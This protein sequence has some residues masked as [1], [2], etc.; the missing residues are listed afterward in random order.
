M[1]IDV[2][3]PACGAKLKLAEKFIRRGLV[4]PSC[5]H[6]FRLTE[7]AERTSTSTSTSAQAKGDSPPRPAAQPPV[8]PASPPRSVTEQRTPQLSGASSQARGNAV[9]PVGRTAPDSGEDWTETSETEVEAGA[10]P[11]RHEAGLPVKGRKRRIS[12]QGEGWPEWYSYALG[13]VGM[14]LLAVIQGLVMRNNLAGLSPTATPTQPSVVG[15]MGNAEASTT[16]AAT[17]KSLPLDPYLSR[18]SQ[19]ELGLV[20]VVTSVVMT[21]FALAG[22]GAT[23]TKAGKPAWA[24]IVPV[25]NVVLL[26]KLAGR[27]LWWLLMLCIPFVNLFVFLL[28]SIDIAHNF[29]KR[30]AFGLGLTFLGFVFYP[31][32]GFGSAHYRPYW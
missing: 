18:N 3:C 13:I 2:S 23:F 11:P 32:L 15:Q 14:C 9:A 10:L 28:M 1:A 4:C 7:E 22:I 16:D 17:E 21:L 6:Q 26:L 8:S 27:P 30:A 12:N 25:Y 20:A 31:L 29:G 19:R 5:Q 24:A